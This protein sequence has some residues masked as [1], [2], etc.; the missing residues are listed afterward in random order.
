MLAVRNMSLRDCHLNAPLVSSC[1]NHQYNLVIP[2]I[3]LL[4]QVRMSSLKRKDLHPFGT[5]TPLHGN[6][7]WI[8]LAAYGASRMDLNMRSLDDI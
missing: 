5:A 3:T 2:A 6:G 7:E 1:H 8:R 4:P